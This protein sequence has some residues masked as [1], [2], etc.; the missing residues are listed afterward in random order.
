MVAPICFIPG[1]VA[2]A[3][4]QGR[5]LDNSLGRIADRNPIIGFPKAVPTTVNEQVS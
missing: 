3:N 4:F 5:S 2:L 1:L